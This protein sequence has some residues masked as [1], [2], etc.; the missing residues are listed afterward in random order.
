MRTLIISLLIISVANSAMAS[1]K[2]KGRIQNSPVSSSQSMK[3]DFETLGDNQVFVDRVKNMDADR[4][5]RIVQNRA[6]DLNNRLE[7]SIGY[8]MNGSGG[9]NYVT[10]TNIGGQLDWHFSPRWAI[11]LRYEKFYNELS[12]EAEAQFERAINDSSGTQ[13]FPDVDLPLSTTLA[14]V[15]FAPIY[16]KLN[17]FDMSIAHFDVYT[18]VGAGQIELKSGKTEIYT[19]GLGMSVWLSQHFSTRL[20][21]RYESYTDLLNSEE[22]SQS[23]TKFMVTLGYLL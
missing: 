15:T 4:K 2:K 16:G 8:G 13:I 20:E 18:V 22:R 12:K 3:K 14:T 1:V 5:V 17:L 6:V 11:G 9:D 19:G 23:A 21:G 10:T 7:L